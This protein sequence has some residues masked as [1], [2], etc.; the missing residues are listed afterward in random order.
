MAAEAESAQ[1]EGVKSVAA[2]GGP[3]RKDGPQE[4]IVPEGVVE[5]RVVLRT[6]NVRDRVD[7]GKNRT[8]H[9]V[10]AQTTIGAAE[11]ADGPTEHGMTFKV[12][13][14]FSVELPNQVRL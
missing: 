13:G 5:V 1:N 2:I 7:V 14:S 6:E 9:A 11:I 8:E 4:N 10:V 3:G 12:H